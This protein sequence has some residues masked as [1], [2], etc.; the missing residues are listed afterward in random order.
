MN[1]IRTFV[2]LLISLTFM[3][4]APKLPTSGTPTIYDGKWVGEM[5]G[6]TLSCKGITVKFDVRYGHILGNSYYEGAREADFWGE[7]LPN[8]KLA[9]NVGQ[10]GISGASADIQF[11]QDSGTGTWKSGSC[12]G[13]VEVRRVG[14]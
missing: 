14:M 1:F 13:S 4:C 12:G 8:G 3:G 5:Q 2:V 10:L 7:I 11:S 6:K 9:A